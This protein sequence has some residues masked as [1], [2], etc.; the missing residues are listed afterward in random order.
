[1]S[2]MMNESNLNC[3]RDRVAGC[4]ETGCLPARGGEVAVCQ[5][6]APAFAEDK[7]LP[8]LGEIGDIS[9]FAS[10]S[11]VGPGWFGISG[12][13]DRFPRLAGTGG[14]MTGPRASRL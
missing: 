5:S 10:S 2:A 12:F 3:L 8:I 11:A 13:E 9:A 1:M 6:A 14:R 4:A 7:A